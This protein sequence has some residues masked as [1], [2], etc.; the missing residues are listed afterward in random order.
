MLTRLIE[1]L[2]NN[3]PNSN[4]DEYLD[5]KYIQ[6][7]NDQLKKIV[8]TMRSGELEIKNASRCSA[9][10]FILHFGSTLILVKQSAIS[11]VTYDSELAWETDFKSI[12]STKDTVKGFYFIKFNFDDGYNITLLETDKREENQVRNEHQENE[13]IT[14]IMPILKGFMSAI[15]E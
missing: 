9:D 7:Q 11:S 1:F 14:K 12:D 15:S 3:F 13:V 4:I 6:L 10:N 5:T 2:Q 8:T